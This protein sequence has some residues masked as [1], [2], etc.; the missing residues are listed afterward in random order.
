MKTNT[1]D[2]KKLPKKEKKWENNNLRWANNKYGNLKEKKTKLIQLHCA[3]VLVN[4]R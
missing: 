4:K 1:N 3:Y 2:E